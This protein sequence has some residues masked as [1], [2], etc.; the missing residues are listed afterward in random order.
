MSGSDQRAY[1]ADVGIEF[2]QSVTELVHVLQSSIHFHNAHVHTDTSIQ[3]WT[4]RAGLIRYIDERQFV[5]TT[6]MYC[7]SYSAVCAF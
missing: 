3:A 6:Y 4:A 5:Y 7:S 2:C 1:L